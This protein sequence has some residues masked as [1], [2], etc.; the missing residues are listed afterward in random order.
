[1][2]C[3][4]L[5]FEAWHREGRLQPVLICLYFT[6]RLPP[7]YA[8]L[9]IQFEERLGG[10][11]ND[12]ASCRS[13]EMPFM[14]SRCLQIRPGISQEKLVSSAPDSYAVRRLGQQKVRAK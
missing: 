8:R 9:R 13:D 14:H 3:F 7:P 1:M 6:R 5:A 10:K 11:Q 2:E 12:G 4:K